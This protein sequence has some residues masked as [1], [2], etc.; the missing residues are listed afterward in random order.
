MNN[1]HPFY[2]QSK[3]DALKAASEVHCQGDVDTLADILEHSDR[4]S[5]GRAYELMESIGFLFRCR[6]ICQEHHIIKE[7]I[8]L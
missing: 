7:A 1:Q 6:A 4:I 3:Q 5:S 8:E 2:E